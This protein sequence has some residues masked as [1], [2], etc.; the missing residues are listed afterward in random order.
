MGVQKS[1]NEHSCNNRSFP[2]HSTVTLKRIDLTGNMISEIEDGAFSKLTLLEV[3]SLAE[4]RLVKLPMLPAKLTSFS[5]NN[6]F[7]K[8]N[9]VKANAFKV[10]IIP[11]TAF[12]TSRPRVAKA[13]ASHE[14][15]AQHAVFKMK[16]GCLSNVQ[17]NISLT[18]HY[19]DVWLSLY[20]DCRATVQLLT[21][22]FPH[23]DRTRV[24][25]A[26]ESCVR[27]SQPRFVCFCFYQS[28]KR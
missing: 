4:N 10:H 7:L 5:A 22:S 17:C 26:G 27:Y 2:H 18:D 19:T 12:S 23:S 16:G 9:G 20:S 15:A 8:T 11:S 3:L 28:K 25:L 21:S 14:S 1:Q 13:T 6:N 24:R